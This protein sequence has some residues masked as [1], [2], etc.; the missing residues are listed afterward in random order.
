MNKGLTLSDELSQ[1]K[2]AC[3]KDVVPF[4]SLWVIVFSYTSQ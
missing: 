1:R 4:S 3:P 2:F